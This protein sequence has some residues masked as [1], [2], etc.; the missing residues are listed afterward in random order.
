MPP[1]SLPLSP[2]LQS[3]DKELLDFG[4]DSDDELGSDVEEGEEGSEEEGDGGAAAA[5][6]EAAAAVGG[7]KGGKDRGG[8]TLAMVEG[9]CA[10]AR[11]NASL[12]AVR[13]IM[14]VGGGWE[15]MWWR[16]L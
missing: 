15:G 9:W 2:A 14:K 3:T 4:K 12:G 5:A 10:A 8:V 6:A 11:E 13:N 7:K 16:G 1:S